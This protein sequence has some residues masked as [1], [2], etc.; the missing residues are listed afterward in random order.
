MLTLD[1]ILHPVVANRT[2]CVEYPYSWRKVNVLESRDGAG[3]SQIGRSRPAEADK[4]FLPGLPSCVSV[5]DTLV[6]LR[7]ADCDLAVVTWPRAD[8]TGLM[9]LDEKMLILTSLNGR[10]VLSFSS[11]EARDALY[12]TLRRRGDFSAWQMLSPDLWKMVALR[13]DH[14]SWGRLSQT[15]SMMYHHCNGERRM[16]EMDVGPRIW[17]E[18]L[19]ASNCLRISFFYPRVLAEKRAFVNQGHCASFRMT[20]G[21]QNSY[22]T[23]TV[24]GAQVCR[25][26]GVAHEDLPMASVMSNWATIR[27]SRLQWVAEGTCIA[28]WKS[29]AMLGWNINFAVEGLRIEHSGPVRFRAALVVDVTKENDEKPW[30]GKVHWLLYA[31]DDK[32]FVARGKCVIQAPSSTRRIPVE[33]DVPGST[34]VVPGAEHVLVVSPQETAMA[35]NDPWLPRLEMVFVES[36]AGI[37]R[38]LDITQHV[39]AQT[40]CPVTLVLPSYWQVKG[41]DWIALYDKGNVFR[42]HLG[43]FASLFPN[44]AEVVGQTHVYKGNVSLPE[45]HFVDTDKEF[46]LGM[47]TGRTHFPT[48]VSNVFSAST[49]AFAALHPFQS[50]GQT[51]KLRSVIKRIMKK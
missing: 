11:S 27:E 50:G 35:I 30:P 39:I 32:S 47:V 7:R 40:I 29:S 13:C 38:F 6:S 33:I 41:S 20:G 22:S 37:A 15:C 17:V 28:S 1:A 26:G 45:K 31:L 46:I 3:A 51:G 19:T 14:A 36:H 18:L 21:T 5:S 42:Y 48:A 8:L 12:R 44:E 43:L 2:D 23:L 16:R 4:S 9:R 34:V 10:L 24:A 25:N 49:A